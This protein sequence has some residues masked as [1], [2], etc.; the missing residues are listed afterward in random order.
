MA[1]V[2]VIEQGKP[3][4]LVAQIQLTIVL[5]WIIKLMGI[6]AIYEQS[7]GFLIWLAFFPP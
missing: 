2:S 5:S 1:Q 7:V 6:V 3:A 4:Y